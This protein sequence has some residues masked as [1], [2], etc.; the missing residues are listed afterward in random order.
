LLS[1]ARVAV[2]EHVPVPLVTVI[3]PVEEFT[4]HAVD[5][6]ALKL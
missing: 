1:P 3:T 4:V 6:P 5:A 2:S